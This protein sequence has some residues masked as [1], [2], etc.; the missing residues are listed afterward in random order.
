MRSE[1]RATRFE[2]GGIAVPGTDEPDFY[3]L[4]RHL[5][6]IFL[7]T[8]PDFTIVAAS[9]DLLRTTLTWRED[10]TGR[11]MFEV[12]PDNPAGD[13]PD[14]IKKLEASLRSVVASGVPHSIRLLRYDIE[15]RVAADGTWIE[16]FWTVIT[17]PV[18][19][20]T[21]GEVLYVLT[22]VRDITRTVQ[23]VLWLGVHDN[24][25]PEAERAVQRVRHAALSQNPHIARIR[26]SI[27]REMALTGASPDTL[28][29][30]LKALVR[31]PES[32]L[33]AFAGEWVSEAGLYIAYHRE[34]CRLA[35]RINYF[36]EGER[37]PGCPRC[38]N[39][40]LFRMSHTHSI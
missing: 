15:N 16:K 23:L 25:G 26:A 14:G 34:G 30:E 6:G 24:M 12:F 20:L 27:A 3:A 39:D 17:R 8:L 5:P 7:V 33:Y 32:R 37:L 10:I 19:D 9:D 18:V 31:S 40:V 36:A 11:S 21:T 1:K 29:N 28:V 22:E 2:A 4:F 35:S 13:N 38:G